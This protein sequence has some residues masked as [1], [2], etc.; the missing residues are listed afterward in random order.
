MLSQGRSRHTVLVLRMGVT[1]CSL[2]H[3]TDDQGL[4]S[5]SADQMAVI[6]SHV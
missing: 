2:A 3:Q 4:I 6:N 1:T 5:G